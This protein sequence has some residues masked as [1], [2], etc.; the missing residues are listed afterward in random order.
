MIFIFSSPRSGSTWLAKAFDSHPDTLY[1]HEPDIVDRGNDLVPHWFAGASHGYEE[2]ASQYLSRLAGN[3]SLR[4]V[5]TRPVFRKR[6]RGEMG[7]HLHTGLIYA[8][9]ALEKAGFRAIGER[10][11]VPDLIKPGSAPRIVMKSVSALGRVEV[12]LKSAKISP[13]LLIRHPCAFVNSYLRGQEMGLMPPPRPLGH[14]LHT[15]SG[16]RFKA[17]ADNDD[18]A[19]HLAWEW[20]LANCEAHAA[21]SEAGGIIL[22]YEDLAGSPESELR[23][24]FSRLDLEWSDSTGD[25]LKASSSGNGSYYSLARDPVA[26]VNKWRSSMDARHVETVR[27]IVSLDPIGRQYFL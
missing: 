6:Y 12:F 4:T 7:R 18:V 22:R 24:L 8:G 1:L 16:R 21:I 11:A 2:A 23:S 20:L 19:K 15:R 27:N 25:F 10:I 9:K 5:G 13:V 3:R 14:L 26:A 17:S